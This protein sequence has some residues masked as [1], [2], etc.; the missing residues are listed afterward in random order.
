MGRSPPRTATARAASRPGRPCAK[1]WDTRGPGAMSRR[2]PGRRAPASAGSGRRLAPLPRR[3]EPVAEGLRTLRPIDGTGLFVFGHGAGRTIL[4]QGFSGRG[5]LMRAAALDKLLPA[6]RLAL[7]NLFPGRGRAVFLVVWHRAVPV[8]RGC[9]GRAG[10]LCALSPLGSR[11]AA[12]F[13]QVSRCSSTSISSS[14]RRT[15]LKPAAA[16]ISHGRSLGRR[17]SGSA[18]GSTA[19]SWPDRLTRTATAKVCFGT[20]PLIADCPLD[21]A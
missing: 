12:R 3:E 9:G 8:L 15:A 1:P 21:T 7:A 19:A 14:A 5:R 2:R 20:L 17:G 6:G 4:P 18:R 16:A 11:N 13:D 10:P